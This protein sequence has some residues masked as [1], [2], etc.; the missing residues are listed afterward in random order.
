MDINNK[1]H[2]IMGGVDF[3]HND[4]VDSPEQLIKLGDHILAQ[5]KALGEERQQRFQD[6]LSIFL[7]DALQQRVLATH[8]DTGFDTMQRVMAELS[9]RSGADAIWRKH[10]EL[11]KQAIANLGLNHLQVEELN[12]MLDGMPDMIIELL[13]LHASRFDLLPRENA[14]AIA[15]VLQDILREE[16]DNDQHRRYS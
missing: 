12:K 16:A 7:A 10:I 4:A 14:A 1:F 3:R 13:A 8:H 6:L 9:V 11:A 2:E 15:S 5:Y